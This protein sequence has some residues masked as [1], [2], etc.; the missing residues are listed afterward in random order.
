VQELDGDGCSAKVG[1][2]REV[3]D[4]SGGKKSRDHVVKS[5]VARLDLNHREDGDTYQDE[6]MMSTH[7]DIKSVY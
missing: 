6:N 7:I 1:S 3:C 4:R 5:A 2:H